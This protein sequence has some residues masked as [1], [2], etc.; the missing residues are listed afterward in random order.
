[1]MRE[2]VTSVAFADP[3]G[4]ARTL[5]SLHEIFITSGSRHK[6]QA[7]SDALNRSLAA[8][9][10]ADLALTGL[11]RFLETS[12]NRA[13]L[14]NDLT[15]YPPLLDLL[16]TLF[17]SSSYFTDILVREPG[18]FRWLTTSDALQRPLRAEHLQGERERLTAAFEKPDSRM[19]AFRRFHRREIL[20]IGTRDLLAL[21]DLEET[22]ASLS[23]L[24][25]SIIQSAL[26]EAERRMSD[27]YPGP[28]GTPFAVIGLGKLGGRELNYSSDVDLLFLYGEDGHTGSRGR[29]RLTRLEY[30][31][32]LAEHLIQLLSQ[33][34][35]EG[36][37]YRVDVRLRPEAG[38]GPLA[39]SLRSS[40]SYY[41]SRG[42]LWERQMLLKARCVAGD[43]A[44]GA[45]FLSSLEPF[46]F[47]RTF[48]HHPA[49]Y[50]ARI[51]A[52]IE[53]TTGD[54]RNLKL[55]PGGIRDVEFVVQTLQLLHAGKDTSLRSVHTLEAIQRLRAGG[56]L[57]DEDEKSLRDGYVFLRTLEHRL[58]TRLNT[59]THSLPPPGPALDRLARSAS[60]KDGTELES[61]VRETAR[62]VR[63]VFE[64]LVGTGPPGADSDLLALLEGGAA[65]TVIERFC[66]AHGLKDQ[67]GALKAIRI[68][69]SGSA[70]ASGG[71]L[72]VRVRQAFR[73]VAAPLFHEISRTPDPDWT[74]SNLTVLAGAA[75]IPEQMYRVL[76]EPG[77]RK[78]VTDVCA[79]SPRVAR[80]LAGNP[81]LLDA[82]A[83]DPAS[84]LVH[85]TLGKAAE[86]IGYRARGELRAAVLHILGLADLR[87]VLAR[88]T[89]I[90]DEIVQATVAGEAKKMKAR[91]APLA[92][93][94]L[95][96]YGTNELMFDSDLDLLF[97]ARP[98]GA[99]RGE[100]L[101]RLASSTVTGLS[102]VTAE[103][104]LYDVDV[105]L[106]PEG[107]NAPLVT[108]LRG[109]GEYLAGRSSLWE[110]QSLTRL[111][112]V[113]GDEKVAAE[114][115]DL[116]R[117]YIRMT[118]LPENWVQTIVTMRQR[119]ES[120]S[121]TRG[122][123]HFDLKLS[124][125]GMADVEFIAQMVVLARGPE[126]PVG[127]QTLDI[128]SAARGREL[129]SV[130]ID[131]LKS[132]YTLYRRIEAGMRL[133]LEERGTIL[134]EGPRLELLARCLEHAAGNELAE[135]L[136]DVAAGVRATFQDFCSRLERGD[137]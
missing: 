129:A 73:D 55:M 71:E 84:F 46:V 82:L 119:M 76:R 56:L 11:S 39:R 91:H 99:G 72:D 41:E 19:D 21:A 110:R 131:R 112:F 117:H 35:Q 67:R 25:E 9:A 120:R 79:M 43:P 54:G 107:R 125:G 7:F 83:A 90:A 121:R 48:L 45:R 74:L 14:L 126:P 4:A 88:V 101:Q 94:G 118:P 20:R 113:A 64:K 95:G 60:V 75:V 17:G 116:V 102:R 128:V 28:P 86:A 5:R 92:A 85:E 57:S 2:P 133:I 98:S 63:S 97:L 44:L 15:E 136:A 47:P 106:R 123:S 53:A 87:T 16:A 61:R 127:E 32:R 1:M 115:M 23:L 114:A 3:G 38:A 27:R 40:L 134:P 50:V 30:F 100:S 42:E 70:L 93:F 109:Y 96:K 68:L 10:D 89:A 51:K 80:G 24:A 130:E 22:T 59:Q 13:G 6:V 135:R 37:L 18:L 69:T 105:R 49:E 34:T 36:H 78:L 122:R 137:R 132:A 33:P 77:F 104:R 62:A 31:N 81:L 103:G 52:K 66:T 58:Q 26:S 124:P 108:S 29:S 12:F 111:R 65:G 8:A